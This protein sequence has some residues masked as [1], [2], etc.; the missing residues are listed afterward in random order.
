MVEG[1]PQPWW[2]SQVLFFFLSQVLTFIFVPKFYIIMNINKHHTIIIYNN[3]HY[4]WCQR[5]TLLNHARVACQPLPHHDEAVENKTQPSPDHPQPAFLHS[6]IFL[7]P[8]HRANPGSSAS[9]RPAQGSE[10]YCCYHQAAK[11]GLPT[12]TSKRP[13]F[14][15][16]QLQLPPARP[17]NTT[18]PVKPIIASAR[19]EDS[20]AAWPLPQNSLSPGSPTPALVPH[21]LHL[22]VQHCH[23]TWMPSNS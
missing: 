23:Y 22:L 21:M 7:N 9:L 16:K 8:S 6:V 1:V 17:Y 12:T 19:A 2:L 4:I 13:E 15:P 18:T 10:L 20:P 3:K 5:G 14:Y 11:I